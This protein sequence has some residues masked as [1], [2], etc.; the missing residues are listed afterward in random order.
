MRA[1]VTGADGFLGAHLCR[2]LLNAGHDVTGAALSRKGHTSLD[3]LGI[4]MRVEY[5]DITDSAYIERLVNAYEAEWVFHL[6]AVSIV[7][8]ADANPSRAIRTNTLGTLNV[9]EACRRQRTIQ[10]VV[11][12]S[13]DKAY[14]DAGGVPYTEDMPL[15]PT[16]TYET[17]KAMT[18]MLAQLYERQYG[19]PTV[20][21]RCANLFG[22]ADLNWSRLVPN[23]CRLALSGQPPVVHPSA[24]L[25]RR[26]WLAVEDAA[27]AY[28]LLARA[29]TRG[30][31]YNVGSGT[32]MTAGE[33]ATRV[34]EMA[35]GP[36][37][38][39]SPRDPTYEIPSQ[40]LDCSR[41]R[42]MGWEPR[43]NVGG[44]LWR[45]VQWYREHLGS[46]VAA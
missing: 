34:A 24:W 36:A 45:T 23:S 27:D 44:A 7:R 29:G 14:G 33:V 15:R 25:M 18:D 40:S 4:G 20:V 2:C 32:V 13:S 16:G 5:G 17:S 22:S 19:L 26:E 11:V 39:S 35:G 46:A 38:V 12:A 21:A 1:L 31:A 30:L 37:P 8:V 41:I 3:A 28:V 42:A 10:A 6:A 9:L 43:R